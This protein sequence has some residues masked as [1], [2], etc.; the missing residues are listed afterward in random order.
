MNLAAATQRFVRFAAMTLSAWAVSGAIALA[1]GPSEYGN[2]SSDPWDEFE[3]ENDEHGNGEDRFDIDHADWDAEAEGIELG[4]NNNAF[5]RQEGSN[6]L[7]LVQ[8]GSGNILMSTQISPL[9][10]GRNYADILQAGNDNKASLYQDGTGNEYGLEQTG[11]SNI[12]IAR[13]YGDDNSFQH[14]QTGDNLGF[15]ITQYGG[16]A[17]VV[18]QTGY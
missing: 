11:D 6:S 12:S 9:G 7:E 14:T 10:A 1:D 4:P 2:L 13:Q 15:A 16:S 17:I 18:T 5:V 8:A 3:H